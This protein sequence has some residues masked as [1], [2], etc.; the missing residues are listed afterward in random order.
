MCTFEPHSYQPLYNTHTA[1][2]ASVILLHARLIVDALR[3]TRDPCT[4]GVRCAIQGRSSLPLCHCTMHQCTN[5]YYGQEGVSEK[6]TSDYALR[7]SRWSRKLP[8]CFR[9]TARSPAGCVLS[10]S[11]HECMSAW[12]G[13]G[14]ACMHGVEGIPLFIQCSPSNLALCPM[15]HTVGA[16][17]NFGH[18]YSLQASFIFMPKCC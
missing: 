1:T 7:A 6:T 13:M 10:C 17:G 15:Y 9:R 11:M 4:N 5:P 12:Q 14:T 3:L 18:M 16:H 2:Y 8:A